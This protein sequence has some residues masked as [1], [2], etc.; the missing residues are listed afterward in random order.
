MDFIDIWSMKKGFI[1][2]IQGKLLELDGERLMLECWRQRDRSRVQ[3]LEDERRAKYRPMFERIELMH[4]E[5]WKENRIQGL[6]PLNLRE[7]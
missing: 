2:Y 7:I 6:D 3:D 5:K 4:Q 1:T